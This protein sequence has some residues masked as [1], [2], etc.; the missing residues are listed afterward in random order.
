MGSIDGKALL[1]RAQEMFASSE[2][3]NSES[4]WS[5]LSEYIIPNQ[6]GNF[7]ATYS[8][9]TK[10][11][12]NL[13]DSTACSCASDLASTLHTLVT[14]EAIKWAKFRFSNEAL[15][16]DLEASVWLEKAN[17]ILLSALSASNFNTE[18]N[19]GYNSYVALANMAL[20]LEEKNPEATSF[21]GFSFRALHLSQLA[22]AEDESGMVDTVFRK[23]KLSARNAVA[24]YPDTIS[25]EIR[26]TAEKNPDQMFNFY[27]CL[28]PNDA[29]SIQVSSVGLARPEN[30][31]FVKVILDADKGNILE[32]DG[33]YEFPVMCVRWDTMPEE[34]YGRGPG[35]IALGDIKTLNKLQENTLSMMAMAVRPPLMAVERGV[36]G[37]VN[38]K[39]GAITVV[40]D[41]ASLTAFQTG[42]RWD[43]A[44]NSIEEL[45]NSIKGIFFIDKIIFPPRNQ[46]GAMT[47]TEVTERVNQMQKVLGPTLGRL[48]SELLNPLIRRAFG[49][50]LRR[51]VFPPLPEILNNNMA[52]INIEYV[53]P[54][55]RAQRIE[56]V[57]SIQSWVQYLAFLA[58]TGKIE[59]LDNIDI[60]GSARLAAKILGVPETAIA[61]PDEMD[62]ERQARAQQQQQAMALEAGVKTAD[63]QAKLSKSG[64][65][66]GGTGPE[67]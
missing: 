48:N 38:F 67:Y 40:R 54:L 4:M 25:A 14:N 15:N 52:G 9:G 21:S 8:G 6:F 32:V 12:T 51:G 43:V 62:Q 44:A 29:K 42:T 58:S 50:L 5:V 66:T 49:I 36:L 23:F 13:Y 55:A 59:A 41:Q 7:N 11:T 35:H 24:K 20:S 17:N 33:F 64:G 27:Y 39:P 1:R 46:T 3:Q 53:N 26:K 65:S 37:N 60:D 61:T 56:E 10:N 34:L 16:E 28:Y 18:V 31:P 63:M 19:K 47:A 2:R 57:Q 22:W 30:R 45:R